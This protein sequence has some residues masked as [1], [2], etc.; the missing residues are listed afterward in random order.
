V[1]SRPQVAPSNGAVRSPLASATGRRRFALIGGLHVGVESVFR[2]VGAAAAADR[3]FDVIA[4]PIKSFS[5]D[6]V[7]RL[8]P[9]LPKSTRGN[10]RYVAGTAPLFRERHLDAVW[11]LI[12]VP[13]LPWLLTSRGQVPVIFSTDSTPR[14]LRAFGEHYGHWGGRSDVKFRMR[15]ALYRSFCRRLTAVQAYTEWAAASMRADYGIPAE[16]IRVFPPGIDVALWKPAPKRNR[17]A[18]LR[19]LFV[20]G[21]F[22]RKG[23]DLLLDVFRQSLRGR[24]E[25]DLVTRPEAAA[26]EPGVR[27]HTELTPNDPRLV[28]LYHEADVLVIPTRADCFSIAGLEAM[29]SGVPV[30]TCPVGGVAE[31]LTDGQ[32]G[33]FVPPDDGAALVRTI[34]TL[35]SDPARRTRMGRAG[36]ELALVRYDARLN[37]KRLLNL[38]EEVIHR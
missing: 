5:H 10:L 29:A 8:L 27:V 22:R 21:D 18:L 12:D 38:V 26:P 1:H 15:E 28:R 31:L 17:S 20:G 11:S 9:F 36:R 16:R 34:E 4:I 25:L 14:Q 30:I 23:G 19:L 24:M 33:Y 2:N 13:L 7:E 6:R 35:W 32:E 3:D 37:T